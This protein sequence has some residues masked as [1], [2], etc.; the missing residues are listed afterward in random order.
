MDWR[1]LNG[2]EHVLQLYEEDA[3]LLEAVQ[4]FVSAGLAAGEAIIVIA[5][6][7]HLAQ[8]EAW[9]SSQGVDLTTVRAQGQYIALEVAATLTQCLVDGQ[10]AAPQFVEV[11][12]GVI[13]QAG[14]QYSRVRACGEMGALL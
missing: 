11:V 12:G 9:L 8:L 1:H 2:S 6:P 10:P 7:P 14:R 5:T 4:H 3:Y 13:A